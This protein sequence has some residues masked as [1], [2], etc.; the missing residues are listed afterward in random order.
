MNPDLTKFCVIDV[1]STTTKA[2]L[3]KKQPDWR[4]FRE[5]EPTTVEKPYEDVMFGVT[6]ALRALEKST[7]E[8][9]LENDHPAVPLFST[10]SA[11][12]GLAMVVAGLVREVTTK[13]AERVALGAGAIIQDVLAH[14][15]GRTPY[16]TIEILK[17]L[18]PDIVLMAGGF[19]GGAVFGPVHTAELIRQSNLRPKIGSGA[20]LPIIY[21]GNVM[22]REL[23]Q[24]LLGKAF[25][26]YAVPNIRPASNKENL[27]PARDA[28]H[29]VFLEHVMSRAPGYNKYKTW[30]SAPILPTPDAVGKL[31]ALVSR[32]LGSKILAV[33]IGG[34]TTDVFT[35]YKGR[36]FR[37][38]SANL[39][40]SYSILNVVRQV[41]IAAVKELVDFDISDAELLDRIGNKFLNPT[42]LPK[43]IEDTKI[44]CAVA[45]L[46][47]REAVREH[48]NVMYGKSLSL[49]EEE[50]GW[51]M[52]SR[53]KK[54]SRPKAGG[55]VFQDY[56]IVIGSGGRLSHSPRKTAAM[57]LIQALQPEES[58]E[59]AVD[60][61]FMFPHL[62]ALAQLD[63]KLALELFY[64]LGLIRLGRLVVGRGKARTGVPAL[65]IKG[66]T[67]R[68]RVIDETVPFGEL[69]T[70]D[71]DDGERATLD[72]KAGK[73]TAK[74]RH[75]KI[76]GEHG[77]LFADARGRPVAGG[78][79]AFVP[80]DHQPA[81]RHQKGD[82]S[83]RVIEGEIRVVRELAVPG[84]VLVEPGEIVT[85]ET[86]IAKSTRAFLRPFFLRIAD[87]IEVTPDQ[88]PLYLTR[89]VGEEILQ[90]EV[91]AE[92]KTYVVVIK[93]FASPV[94]GTIERILPD[95]TVVVREK[96]EHAARL[97]SVN[98]IRELQVHPENVER[99]LKCE[100]G[101]EIEKEQVLAAT[102]P[103]TSRGSRFCRSPVRGRVREINLEYGSILIE[104]L[105]EEL[106]L[107]AWLPGRVE[108]VSD[109][110]CTIVNTGTTVQGVWGNDRRTH[111]IIDNSEIKPGHVMICD[112]ANRELLAQ[113]QSARAAGLIVGGIH[114][115]D[116]DKVKPD[117]AVVV[118]DGFGVNSISGALRTLLV[119]CEG[120]LA[121]IDAA[122]QLRAGV[123]RPQVIIPGR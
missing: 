116:I 94:S 28:I 65:T 13:S 7:G 37:T 103:V 112:T 84:E 93:T 70:I 19:D 35:A 50:L 39:G 63:E 115:E 119:S 36:A 87:K 110:G 15:D 24:D 1:G 26:V 40:M 78:P 95:G 34:A 97:H 20:L 58:V 105:L 18:R 47:V 82:L 5:E 91:L 121:C 66:V 14:D 114:L 104:P 4:Y 33:D 38:V 43:T 53:K 41:G 3:F 77:S 32:D 6:N 12:G 75:V 52:F 45:S 86:I 106:D 44:E 56:D 120:R 17:T 81:I 102:G 64:K 54:R 55:P 80:D 67:S 9:L 122:T 108:D 100:P 113:M 21:A 73:V 101:Q 123:K 96:Q 117:F 74:E 69:V 85:P 62:G 61:V 60:S 11:G 79:P 30:V 98:V 48:L 57:I 107:N 59:L 109:R 8:R 99:C 29:E 16:K 89:K 31:L 68:A 71:V 90:G 51:H 27:E 111:G 42:G 88:L 25:M 10:S 2:I 83:H 118:T 22:A 46:A 49:T 76:G 23:V 72:I 92:K